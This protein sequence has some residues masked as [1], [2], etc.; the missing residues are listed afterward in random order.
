MK[1][2]ILKA[3]RFYQKYLRYGR[4]CRFNPTCSEYC[5]QAIDSYDIMPGG[6][7]ALKRIFRCHPWQPGGNDPLSK[8]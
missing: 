1:K 3:I 4:A 6:W 5:Y 2:L 8:K 7:L